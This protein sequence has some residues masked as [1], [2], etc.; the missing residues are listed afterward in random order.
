MPA[1]KIAIIYVIHT[2]KNCAAHTQLLKLI[3]VV[4]ANA[5]LCMFR[6]LS[7]CLSFSILSI[8]VIIIWDLQLYRSKKS[9]FNQNVRT[10]L[11]PMYIL[12]LYAY[13]IFIAISLALCLFF[14]RVF[15]LHCQLQRELKYNT[16]LQLLQI[17]LIIYCIFISLLQH[18]IKLII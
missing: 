11:H 14:I 9:S 5:L 8:N 10:V 4:I 7:I 17:D 18:L 1:F 16:K 6:C 2:G 15:P 12:R 13:L 3:K